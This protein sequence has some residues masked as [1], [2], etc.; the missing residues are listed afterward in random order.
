MRRNEGEEATATDAVEESGSNEQQNNLEGR[1][2]LNV[3]SVVQGK[4]EEN[5]KRLSK[6][7]QNV[8]KLFEKLDEI[9]AA[10]DRIN[11]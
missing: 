8:I 9:T 2:V 7:E 1:N 10:I 11:D 6:L 4:Q 5:D 3:S